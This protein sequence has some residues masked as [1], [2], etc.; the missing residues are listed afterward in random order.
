VLLARSALERTGLFD[1]AFFAYL[2]DVD[3]CVR[4]RAAGFRV[5][6]A[7]A[8]IVYHKMHASTGGPGYVTARQYLVARNTVLFARKHASARERVRLV[9]W[10]VGTLPFQLARRFVRREHHGVILKIRGY[11]DGL[12]NRPLPLGE[13][14]LQ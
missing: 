4:A 8:A 5:V 9:A 14:G 1:E 11:L 3:L 13:L 6:F 10:I 7:P 2:E 12:R